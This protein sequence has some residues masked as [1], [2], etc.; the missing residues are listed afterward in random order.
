MKSKPQ[1]VAS[2]NPGPMEKYHNI[3]AGKR[4]VIIGNGPSL[5]KMDLSFLKNEFTIATNRIYLGFEK[6]DFVPSYYV[7]VNPLVISQS[8]NEIMA[9]PSPKFLSR[10][11]EKFFKPNSKLHFLDS[12]N[13][14]IFSEDPNKGI[15]EG[16]TVTYVCMQ[17]AY[18]FGFSEIFLIGVDHNYT[19][20]G[21]PNQEVVANGQDPNHFSPE[22]FNTGTH[23]H[24]PDL[25]RSEQGYHLANLFLKNHNR[26][27]Y[28]ATLEGKLTEF[29]KVDYREVFL[30]P[31]KKDVPPEVINLPLPDEIVI[32]NSVDR[33]YKISAITSTFRGERFIKGCLDDLE[34][35]SIANEMEIIVIDSGSEQN[36]K[37][38]VADYQTRFDNIVYIRTE[39]K[40]TVYAAWNRGI[41]HARGKYIT[42]A[43]V[44][45]RHQ[46]YALEKLSKILDG[47]EKISLV[48]S[49][50][51]ITTQE[52]ANFETGQITGYYLFSD[53]DRL[54]MYKNCYIGP[55]PLWRKS[56]HDKYGYFDPFYTSA[57][58]YEFWLRIAKTEE[59]YHLAETLGLYLNSPGSA[60]HRNQQVSAMEQFHAVSKHLPEGYKTVEELRSSLDKKI[61]LNDKMSEYIFKI[62]DYFKDGN[63]PLVLDTLQ[64]AQTEF[65]NH[66][67]LINLRGMLFIRTER[68][69]DARKEFASAQAISSSYLPAIHNHAISLDYLGRTKEA[70]VLLEMI[71][72]SVPNYLPA[73]KSIVKLLNKTK[74]GI[75]AIDIAKKM[76]E[77]APHDYELKCFLAD[78]YG[79][80]NDFFTATHFYS[81]L[82]AEIPD[83][84]EIQE[85]IF[86]NWLP[87]ESENPNALPVLEKFNRI[88]NSNDVVSF[89]Q[90]HETWLDEDLRQ[91]VITKIQ[92]A[93]ALNLHEVVEALSSLKEFIEHYIGQKK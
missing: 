89:L 45:D 1:G 63:F 46:A 22:Y 82:L 18:Y 69:E 14:W 38:I 33:P 83:F 73:G 11:G 4:C 37:S 5:N 80:N 52:N 17:L 2:G 34:A 44:D 64:Q 48:Y 10:S 87:K 92:E 3:H 77:A 8:V 84:F 40:E 6:F 93:K 30:N 42:N 7:C 71:L 43:N 27:I 65:P 26:S 15:F 54:R 75:R 50:V 24:L 86:N 49:D 57:G 78:Y 85:Q 88:V 61:T 76:L 91:F 53:F 20:E 31:A 35:Q 41:K 47:N 67:V 62:G 23:W 32:D 28:D 58:D 19:A 90:E 68:Y 36:E 66:P 74:Q 9:I 12:L 16:W 25:D 81:S 70:I 29:P 72:K 51:A 56:L 13:Q 59:F 55:Q 39:K 79:A 60:E 21:K